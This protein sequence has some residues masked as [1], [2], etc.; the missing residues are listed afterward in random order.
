MPIRLRDILM[1]KKDLF[2]ILALDGGGTAG[3][4]SAKIL[5]CLE[6]SLNISVRDCFDLIAGTSTGSIIAGAAA[7]GIDM[8]NVVELFEYEGPKI[9]RKKPYRCSWFFSKYS[10]KPL[11]EALGEHLSSTMKLGDISTPLMIMSS[12]ISTGGVW[13]FKSAYMEEL[14]QPY[15]RDGE[16]LLKDAILSSCAAPTFFAPQKVYNALQKSNSLLTDGGLWANNP[17]IYAYIEA[18]SKFQ[19]NIDQIRILSIGTAPEANNMYKKKWCWG[20]LTGWE[21]EKFIRYILDLQSLASTNM[22]RLLLGD[23]RYLRIQPDK[24]GGKLDKTG[25]KYFITLISDADK[26]FEKIEAEIME[27]FIKPFTPNTET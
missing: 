21:H 8:E 18:L 25:T 24:S 5:D 27:N 6:K 26:N 11:E 9:F 15:N 20:F 4:Y 3:I 17:S 19:K 14:G 7:I 16:L 12:D 13:V 2:Y 10:I 23:D 22:A 1:S